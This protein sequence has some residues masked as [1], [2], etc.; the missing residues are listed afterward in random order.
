MKKKGVLK[1]K[2]CRQLFLPDYRNRGR[3]EYCNKPGCR[4]V[5]KKESQRRWLAKPENRNYF[6]GPENVNRVRQWR[7]AHPRYWR[8]GRGA[9]QDDC[10]AQAVAAESIAPAKLPLQDDCLKTNPLI[11]G[12]ISHFS[13]ALQDD[14]DSFVDRLQTKGQMILGRGPGIG[15]KKE[16][17]YAGEASVMG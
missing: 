16:A 10:D 8:K 14:I 3:Q 2:H 11:I 9:L 1:C 15:T 5:H 7:K 4:E 6:K 13:G 12:L 17:V